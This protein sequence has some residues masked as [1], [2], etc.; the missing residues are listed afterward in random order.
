M[1]SEYI[2]C[3]LELVRARWRK[4]GALEETGFLYVCLFTISVWWWS[5]VQYD[6]KQ[7]LVS[8]NTRPNIVLPVII[9]SLLITVV[10]YWRALIISRVFLLSVGRAKTERMTGGSTRPWTDRQWDGEKGERQT[11]G[12]NKT[13]RQT[14][15]QDKQQQNDTES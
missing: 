15:K 8:R 2:H 7:G 11:I 3:V 14:R 12:V 1:R 6:G 4:E 5:V 10:K 9:H 13:E